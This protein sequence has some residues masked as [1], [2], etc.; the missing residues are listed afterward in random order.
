VAVWQRNKFGLALVGVVF[1]SAAFAASASAT[2]GQIEG[3]SVDPHLASASV[4]NLTVAYD[5]CPTS[6]PACSWSATALLVPP[7]ETSCPVAWSWILEVIGTAP[8]MPPPPP[9]WR[10]IRR[11]W[12]AESA[13][14]GTL[15]SGPLLLD[16]E[17]VNDY[18][19]CL[20]AKH[21]SSNTTAG[22]LG[23]PQPAYTPGFPTSDLIASQ[24]LHVDQ[25]AA[26]PKPEA[27]PPAHCKKGQR[28]VRVH[29]KTR[30]KKIHHHR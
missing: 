29:G 13:G 28:R 5:A 19:L 9:G 4:Q 26:S 18:R 16:L 25:P 27:R 30:C 8:S 3:V 2:T 10:P 1:L 20:Y 14:N 17:G 23:S 22:S 6:E 12:F 24:L 15:Q 21:P 11:I 7:A